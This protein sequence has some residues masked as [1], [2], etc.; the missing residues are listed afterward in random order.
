MRPIRPLAVLAVLALAPTAR[1]AGGE[2]ARQCLLAVD[3]LV[4]GRGAAAVAHLGRAREAHARPEL[5]AMVGLVGLAS[6]EPAAGLRSLESAIAHGSSEPW[7]RYWA[8]RAALASGKRELALRRLTEAAAVAPREPA[9]RLGQAILLEAGGRRD[10]ARAAVLAVAEVEPFLLSPVLYPTPVE[11]AIGL[12]GAVLR[13]LPEPQRLALERTQAQLL[14][15]AGRPAA[16]LRR[17]ERLAASPAGARDGELL[18]AQALALSACGRSEAALSLA[19]RASSLAPA[20]PRVL[21]ARGEILLELGK[22][23][24]AVPDLRRAADALPRDAELLA[25]LAQACSQAERS[26]CAERFYRHALNREP[27]LA[28]AHLGLA[29]L[30]ERRAPALARA[31]YRRALTLDPSLRRAYQA[32]AQLARLEKDLRWARELAAAERQVA[33]VQTRHQRALARSRA[34]AALA[35]AIRA[36]LA[37]EPSCA[38]P[39]C[40]TLVGKLPAPAS[41]LLRAALA[42]RGGQLGQASALGSEVAAALRPELLAADPALLLSK[43]QAGPLRFELRSPLPAVLPSSF[44]KSLK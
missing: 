43:G 18:A 6:G 10:A 31:S 39:T 1:A 36:E 15:R 3:A 22:A 30:L 17:L 41:Q 9:I 37:S 35:E 23:S 13:G 2:L 4:D 32:A 11:G 28:S 29:L 19:E 27:R 33:P 34:L 8:G 5:D 20:S 21:A 42:W 26:E 25:R 14:W 7:V 38:R 40:R 24:R 12:L 44:R 16:A